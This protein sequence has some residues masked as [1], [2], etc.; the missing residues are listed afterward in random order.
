MK[1]I[2]YVILLFIPFPLS[3]SQKIIAFSGCHS[4]YF[5]SHLVDTLEMHWVEVYSETRWPNLENI[6]KLWFQCPVNI[7]RDS[8]LDTLI[9]FVRNGGNVVFGDATSGNSEILNQ[10]LTDEHWQ[11]D[12][13]LTNELI[14]IDTIAYFYF[15]PP[16]TNSV[17]TVQMTD[18]RKI[19]IIGDNAF[20]FA[21]ADSERNFPIA[22][23]SYPFWCE[24]N[25]SSYV[26]LMTGTHSWEIDVSHPFDGIRFASNILLTSAGAESYML[27]PC[28]IPY[29]HFLDCSEKCKSSPNPFTP[30]NDGENDYTYFTFDGIGEKEATIYIYD[31]RSILVRKIYVPAGAEAKSA[32]RWDGRD[33]NRRSLP[34]GLYLYVIESDGEVVCDGTITLAR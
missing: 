3:Y 21:F 6:T 13:E 26:I 2:I 18:A 32:A 15:F 17:C 19:N 22:A 12:L 23:I 5:W 28:M 24:G 11:T 8:F 20:P 4:D 30:N 27:E 33:E 1:K 31:N 34:Q 25:C 9:D 16:F 7:P 10:I 29:A 14:H